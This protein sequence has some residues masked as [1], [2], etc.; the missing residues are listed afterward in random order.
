MNWTSKWFP[1]LLKSLIGK[2]G[3]SDEQTSCFVLDNV[4]LKSLIGKG[5]L[6][7]TPRPNNDG[8]FNIS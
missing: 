3:L 1:F 5:G 4:K 7:D 8:D 6:S 2:G